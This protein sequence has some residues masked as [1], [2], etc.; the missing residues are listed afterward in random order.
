[1]AERH[2]KTV[3]MASH[4][5]SRR[6]VQEGLQHAG[7]EFCLISLFAMA[8]EQQISEPARILLMNSL[9][10]VLVLVGQFS[11]RPKLT[12]TYKSTC[13]HR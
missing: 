13:D 6:A 7:W 12:E 4:D 2:G 9:G 10:F 5:P 3:I 8:D 11:R 1:M